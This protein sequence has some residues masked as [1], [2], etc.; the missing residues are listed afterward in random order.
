[1]PF[2]SNIT[3]SPLAC[4][5]SSLPFQLQW[6]RVGLM[7]AQDQNQ[8]AMFTCSRKG[9]VMGWLCHCCSV[10]ECHACS[11]GLC[12]CVRHVVISRVCLNS[13]SHRD[14]RFSY[15]ERCIEKRVS[16]KRVARV[17]HSS[18]EGIRGYRGRP[19]GGRS[20]L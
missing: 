11:N 10:T 12:V 15:T 5:T 20:S 1:M 16:E 6:N 18:M 9:C 8:A 2:T 7:L 19:A 4:S 13:T 14:D 17:T 3:K